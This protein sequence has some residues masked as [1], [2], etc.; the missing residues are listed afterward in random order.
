MKPEF[1]ADN[2]AVIDREIAWF[3]DLLERRL[4]RHS[5]EDIDVVAFEHPAPPAISKYRSP[6]ADVLRAF[7]M[8]WPERLVLILGYIPY[9][10][11]DILDPFLIQN[12]SVQRRFTEFGGHTGHWHGGFLPTGETAMFLLAGG[13][14]R[15]RLGFHHLFGEDHYFRTEN[16]LLLDHRQQDEPPLSSGL[17]ITA[18]Y[19]ERL[20]TGRPHHPPYSPEFPAQRITT[21]YEWEDLVLD[22]PTHQEIDDIVSWVRHHDT[23][24]DTWMLRK[25]LKAGYRSLFYG[26]PGTGKTMTASLLGKATGLSVYRIDLSKVV[27]K[28]IGETEKNLAG[29]FDHAQHQNWILF[30]D[31][32]DS[33][34]GKRTESRNAN[35]RAANQQVSYLLQRIEDFPGVVIL[36][37]NLRSQLDEAFARRFQSVVHFRMP[38]AEQRL[39][40]WEDNFKDKPYGLAPDVDLAGIAKQYELS[41]GGIINVLRYAC[42]KAVTRERPTIHQ[43]DLVTGIRRELRKDGKLLA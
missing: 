3:R 8:E 30:F 32:A 24:M 34:F 31:Q 16:I 13:D 40:L 15:A 20:T 4:R 39:R 28:Y 6:Y 25:R 33:L 17:R 41:G 43:D 23:L 2:A 42:L 19:V 12:Q 26:P 9:I 11:P 27:S 38:N 37:T 18:E 22:N 29:L 10:R 7:E 36:A 35:D 14:T 1:F 5:G 21:S